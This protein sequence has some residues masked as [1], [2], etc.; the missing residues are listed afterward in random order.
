IG[1]CQPDRFLPA[2]D[3]ILDNDIGQVDAGNEGDEN[4]SET[5]LSRDVGVEG[6]GIDEDGDG[7]QHRRYEADGEIDEEMTLAAQAGLAQLAAGV[8]CLEQLAQVQRLD[9]LGQ[10]SFVALPEPRLGLQTGL[11]L[12]AKPITLARYKLEPPAKLVAF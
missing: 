3:Q 2:D 1:P 8:F 7:E 11:V 4:G 9:K 12:G 10:K 6:R 5:H